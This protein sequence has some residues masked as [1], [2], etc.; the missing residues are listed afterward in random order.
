[1]L[2]VA[3]FLKSGN[4][5]VAHRGQQCP[6]VACWRR[7]WRICMCNKVI[8]AANGGGGRLVSGEEAYSG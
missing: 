1:M 7:H 3:A 6:L 4:N 2:G 5:H 8:M